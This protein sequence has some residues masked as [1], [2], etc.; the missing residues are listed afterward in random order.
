MATLYSTRLRTL[1]AAK[2][3]VKTKKLAL[4]MI[5]MKKQISEPVAA[6]LILNAI[7][8]TARTTTAGMSAH[9]AFRKSGATFP[10][11]RMGMEVWKVS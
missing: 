7:A 5:Q 10:W 9:I 6:I 3:K 2:S 1:E 8:K 4:M 11:W